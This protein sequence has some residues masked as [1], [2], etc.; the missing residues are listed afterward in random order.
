[1]II[2]MNSYLHYS[3]RID[4]EGVLPGYVNQKLHTPKLT[5]P[6]QL[7]FYHLIHKR[8]YCRLTKERHWPLAS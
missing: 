3:C 7:L 6:G 4:L 2:V 1:M 8:G 5:I